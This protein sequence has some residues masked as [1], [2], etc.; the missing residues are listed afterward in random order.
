MED[1]STLSEA[2]LRHDYEATLITHTTVQMDTLAELK[3]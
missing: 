2:L 3:D 1:G